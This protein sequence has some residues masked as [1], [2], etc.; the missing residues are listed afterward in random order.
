MESLTCALRAQ[1]STTLKVTKTIPD[2]LCMQNAH[3]VVEE[4]PD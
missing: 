4:N 1:V 2:G 3:P